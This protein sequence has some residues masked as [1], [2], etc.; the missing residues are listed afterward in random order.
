MDPPLR[1][2]GTSIGDRLQAGTGNAADWLRDGSQSVQNRPPSEAPAA[3]PT[4]WPVPTPRSPALGSRL[5]SNKVRNALR[6]GTDR[7]V[8]HRNPLLRKP[9]G[10]Q[11]VARHDIWISPRRPPRNEPHS[12]P[13]CPFQVYYRFWCSPTLFDGRPVRKR[14]TKLQ[15]DGP[16]CRYRGPIDGIKGTAT[17]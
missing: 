14:R 4:G 10:S 11:I 3:C 15:N 6:L 17:E 12:F 8:E 7:L 2:R 13:D 16:V 5:A 1:Q 9:N